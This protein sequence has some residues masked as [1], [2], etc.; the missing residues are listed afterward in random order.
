MSKGGM[1]L[2][3]AAV[4]GMGTAGNQIHAATNVSRTFVPVLRNFADDMLRHLKVPPGF[5]VNVFARSQ[6]NA[7]MMLLLPDGTILMT[8]NDVGQVV[9]LRDT[10]GDGVADASPVVANIP[11]VHGL[12]LRGNTVYLAS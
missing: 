8:R 7:R 6:G 12:A 10:D 9:A 4:I 11:L 3:M 1:F 2:A 5:K